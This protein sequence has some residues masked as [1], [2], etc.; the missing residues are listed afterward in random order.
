MILKQSDD[1]EPQIKELEAL[2]S[3]APT[4][5]KP[6][7]EKE[8]SMLRAGIKGEQE[9]IY[10]IDFNFRDSKNFV[11]IHDLRFEINGNVAQID[12]LIINRILDVY[13]L[14]TKHFHAGIKITDDGEFMQYVPTKKIYVGMPSPIAQNE[15]HIKVLQDIF[16]F[17][18]DMP[19]RLGWTLSPNFHSRILVNN[20]AIVNRSKKFDSSCVIKSDQ[21]FKL[22]RKDMDGT[23]LTSLAK[24][25]SSETIEN[26]AHQLISLHK[27]IKF[28]YRAKFGLDKTDD[29][30][31]QDKV[32]K[33][34]A[35]IE[36]S[37]K[38]EVIEL[39]ENIHS[40]KKC[41]SKNVKI[42][43]GKFGYYYKCSDCDGNSNIKVE[44][45]V[46]G[47]SAKLRKDGNKFFKDCVD[48]KSSNLYFEN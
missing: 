37:P 1:K 4:I 8:L 42:Q 10:Q 47:H 13:C 40:C 24:V 19:T 14:E 38:T 15:R 2:L 25:V 23:S 11:V 9:S 41:K 6:K 35:V 22:F 34:P 27:P 20:S 46:A 33:Q 29:V 16:K 36:Q 32:T 39:T 17:Y 48:C 44:C 28:N 26:I 5:V 21:F 18:V 7:I 3:I 43:Y 12:H 45:L 31:L 30:K